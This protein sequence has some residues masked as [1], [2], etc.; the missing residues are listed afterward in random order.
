MTIPELQKKAGFAFVNKDVELAKILIKDITKKRQLQHLATR[1]D[2]SLVA[3][4][5]ELER[6]VKE[7]E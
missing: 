7:N 2:M 4:K 3:L 5:Q 1:T 6:M